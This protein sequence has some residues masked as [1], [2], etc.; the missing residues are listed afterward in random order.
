ATAGTAA[1]VAVQLYRGT[2]P[3]PGVELL[4]RGASTIPG[5][6]TQDPVAIT[7]WRGVATFRVLA[8]NTPG[9]YRL[10]VAMPNGPPL[11]PTTRAAWS[12]APRWHRSHARRR[13]TPIPGWRATW[14][15]S[16]AARRSWGS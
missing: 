6:A 7:D 9:T 3:Q 10:T 13:C 1:D 2:D 15:S 14:C 5:G 11:G 4:L 8:G 16:G 12:G